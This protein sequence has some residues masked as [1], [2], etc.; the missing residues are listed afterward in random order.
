MKRIFSFILIIFSFYL[1]SSEKAMDQYGTVYQA[2]ITTINDNPTLQINIYNS[3][4]TKTWVVVPGT[5]GIEK[6]NFPNLFYSLNTSNLFVL[7]TKERDN[8]SDLYLQI[9]HKDF[10]FSESYLI[11]E[12]TSSNYCIN[13]KIYQTYK[14]YQNEDGSKT[15]LQLLHII[16]WQ[17]GT[18]EG[19]FYANI[20]VTFNGIDIDA[21]TIIYLNDLVSFEPAEG[22]EISPFLYESPEIFVPKT[23]ENS[24]SLIFADLSSLSYV[25]FDLSYDGENTLRDRAH[26]PDIGVRM[27]Y[28][29]PINLSIGS[30]PEFLVG[31]EG[32]IALLIKNGDNFDFTFF[33]NGSWA[34]QTR[35]SNAS[36]IFEAKEFVKRIIEDPNF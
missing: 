9:M 27:P 21:K 12:G 25:I 23:N 10:T 31:T 35:I 1:F 14:I 7:Y 13:P 30:N 5:E 3:N 11:S 17:K 20:P 29:I 16:W 22:N 2:F 24:L 15:I 36:N 32:R 18:K 34:N 26:F 28:P 33:C 6:E 4:G 8:G 19:A